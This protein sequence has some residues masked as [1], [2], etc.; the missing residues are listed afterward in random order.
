[1]F[2][3]EVLNFDLCF[4]FYCAII[5]LYL[6]LF[7]FFYTVLHFRK[8]TLMAQADATTGEMTNICRLC[9]EQSNS[10]RDDEEIQLLIQPHKWVFKYFWNVG[11]SFRLCPNW[12]KWLKK[13]SGNPL[14]PACQI[15]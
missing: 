7:T 12:V 10:C 9:L 8:D 15:P 3:P 13:P 14:L 6:M 4:D 2:F 5:N 11:A 1:M